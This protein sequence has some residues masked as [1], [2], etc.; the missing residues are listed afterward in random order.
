[1]AE[2]VALVTGAAAGIGASCAKR[3]AKDGIAVGVLDLD[4]ERCA[5]TV[6]SVVSAGGKAVALA[7]DISN[8]SEVETAV[9][10]L[11][12]ALGPVAIVVN[13]AATTG[14]VPF[15]EM[16][17]EQWER[18]LRVNLWGTVVVT[19]VVLPDMIAAGWGRIINISSSAA[20]SGARHMA[21]YAASKG[22]MISLTRTLAVEFGPSGVTA[23]VIPPRFITGTIMSEQS[24]ADQ[25]QPVGRE[26]FARMGPICREGRPEDVAGA[27]AWLA[28]E[29][30]GFVT[31]QVIGV[32]GGRYI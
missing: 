28:S 17:E 26:Q 8:R 13:N 7:A 21:H 19:Q 9:G 15:L 1:L 20:Q 16:T 23:N 10:R 27:V 5:D 12:S 24:F 14:Y 2:K 32:N 4:E 29:E 25:K 11:R 22:G 3:L 18:V 6:E 30:A 31:G